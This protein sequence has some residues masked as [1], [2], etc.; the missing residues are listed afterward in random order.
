[1]G[2]MKVGQIINLT[3]GQLR[4]STLERLNRILGSSRGTTKEALVAEAVR[5]Q[6]DQDAQ[7]CRD[8]ARK[9]REDD[10]LAA[11]VDQ[12]D[13]SGAG[14]RVSADL[15]GEDRAMNDEDCALAQKVLEQAWLWE[16]PVDGYV[17]GECDGR[18]FDD[19]DLHAHHDPPSCPVRLLYLAMQDR[20]HIC[21]A[22][23]EAADAGLDPNGTLDYVR[24]SL[25][26]Q[27]MNFLPPIVVGWRSWPVVA[28]AWCGEDQN[29][30]DNF[31]TWNTLE[32]LARCQPFLASEAGYNWSA[33]EEGQRFIAKA[34]TGGETK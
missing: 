32:H 33:T 3:S 10:P 9:Q 15:D 2:D 1:M 4:E 16:G 11:T 19:H 22:I 25:K 30:N 14:H 23:T 7:V 24:E 12:T 20:E 18:T 8:Y 31:G 21:D 29:A 27:G 5:A 28:C 13:P 34:N 6:R 26:G 17:C